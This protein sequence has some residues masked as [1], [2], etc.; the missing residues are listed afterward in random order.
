M[1]AVALHAPRPVIVPAPRVQ[2]EVHARP[3]SSRRTLLLAAITILTLSA[4]VFGAVALNALAA[5]A[6]VEARA[7]ERQVAAAEQRYGQLVFAVSAKEN[8]AR[9]REMALE[10]GMVPSAAARHLALERPVAADGARA[11]AADRARVPDPLKP[12]LTQER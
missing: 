1:S 6:A 3:R 10:L 4:A 12:V 9:I 7:L 11:S 2:A 5:D 8:P